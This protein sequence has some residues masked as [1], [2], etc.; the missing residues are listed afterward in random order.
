M[1][2]TN[3]DKKFSCGCEIF[4]VDG[5]KV[6]LTCKKKLEIKKQNEQSS[7]NSL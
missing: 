5:K 4:Y 1:K 2:C 7:R 6:C 3:C